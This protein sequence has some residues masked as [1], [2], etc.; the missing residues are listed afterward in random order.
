M[1]PR[2]RRMR[3]HAGFGA[4]I[5]QAHHFDRRNGIDDQFGQLDFA[6]GGRAEAGADLEDRSERVDDRLA[7]D[8]PRSS[9]PQE[10]T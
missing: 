1:N 4:G 5:D 3:A 10:P 8:G 9:G 6:A 7:G 2:A